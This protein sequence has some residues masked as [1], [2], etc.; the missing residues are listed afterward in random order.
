MI[1]NEIMLSESVPINPQNILIQQEHQR[2]EYLW[3]LFQKIFRL[4]KEMLN[5]NCKKFG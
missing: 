5:S 1:S 2:F 3:T 4:F